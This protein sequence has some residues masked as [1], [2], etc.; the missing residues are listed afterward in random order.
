LDLRSYRCKVRFCFGLKLGKVQIIVF[1][2]LLRK[3]RGLMFQ[4]S[5]SFL[6]NPSPRRVSRN[7]SL[8]HRAFGAGQ[9]LSRAFVV[10]LRKSI[11]QNHNLKTAA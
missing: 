9:F 3:A 5:F 10:L 7:K 2:G 4:F 1:V 11:P 8:K 6:S